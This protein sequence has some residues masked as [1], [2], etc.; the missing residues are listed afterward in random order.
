[1]GFTGTQSASSE[2]IPK[3]AFLFED[4]HYRLALWRTTEYILR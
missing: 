3:Y 4:E 1:M 2:E